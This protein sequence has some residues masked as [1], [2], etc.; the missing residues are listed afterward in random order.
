MTATLEKL[1]TMVRDNHTHVF[2]W[3]F[4]ENVPYMVCLDCPLKMT[5]AQVVAWMNEKQ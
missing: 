4:I 1:Y 5:M 2:R 3:V